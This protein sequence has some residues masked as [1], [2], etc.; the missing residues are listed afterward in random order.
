M[1]IGCGRN[2]ICA[3][4]CSPAAFS[5]G[6]EDGISAPGRR[7]VGVLNSFGGTRNRSP[8][9]NVAECIITSPEIMTTVQIIFCG[10]LLWLKEQYSQNILAIT[11]KFEPAEIKRW[12]IAEALRFT[13][14]FGS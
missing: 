14:A 8:C 5:S 7:I 11:H 12:V 6:A 2:R 1:R 13:P 4:S 3:G 10:R 9:P